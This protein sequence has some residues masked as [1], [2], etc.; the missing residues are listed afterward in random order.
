MWDVATAYEKSVQ[1]VQPIA[2]LKVP[3]L[4]TK[5]AHLDPHPA[6]GMR[7]VDVDDFATVLEM[8]FQ[9]DAVGLTNLSSVLES[10]LAAGDAA[11]PTAAK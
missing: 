6:D 7:G 1:Q 3:S 9:A 8:F 2:V 10:Q 11:Q 4:V 5:L